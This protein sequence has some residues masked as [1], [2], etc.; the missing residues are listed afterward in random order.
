MFEA[1]CLALL[2]APEAPAPLR[3]LIDDA[4][5]RNP[6]IAA[7]RE[8]VES[9]RQRPAV[10]RSLPDPMISLGY[11]SVGGPLPGQGLG[12]APTARIGLMASQTLP[13]AGKRA[14]RD[15]VARKEAS[16]VEE[17]YRQ[18]QLNVIA[19][20]KTAWH[21]LHHAYE[22]EDL[23]RRD[24]E[25]LE[26]ALRA[27]EARYAVGKTTQQELLR[28]QTQLILIETKLTRYER[29]R[30]AREAELNTLAARPLAAPI[31]RP[32]PHGPHSLVLSL[33]QL[34]E[35][36]RERAPSI[37]KEQRNIERN[38]LALRLARKDGAPDYTVS[39]G[40]YQMGAMGSMVE[41]KVDF[42]V[43]WFTRSRQRAAAAAQT[44]ALAAA[45][46]TY[47]STAN[48]QMYRVED[49]YLATRE[50]WRLIELATSALLPQ[51]HLAL[52]SA[53]AA[54]ETG[55]G[56]FASLWMNVLALVEAEESYHEAWLDYDLALI[57]LEET[58]GIE[59]LKEE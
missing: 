42:S 23:T 26:R 1:I 56:D 17:E 18:T 28:A 38:E 14:L 53:M 31:A 19:R 12:T 36:A 30:R 22:M 10:E 27:G 46:R 54:Y 34:R 13:G 24:R 25:L 4:L 2:L 11:A 33:E 47:Q 20:V 50:A 21:R 29:E 44:H 9:A 49:D 39:A 57:R 51:A 48:N 52:D 45:R 15:G 16:A 32:R 37:V 55:Q 7:A 5:N 8:R 40:Y 43:P 35:Q 6:E 58:T 41:A 59:L 3:A